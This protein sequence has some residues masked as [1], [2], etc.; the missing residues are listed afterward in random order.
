MNLIDKLSINYRDNADI[1]NPF[2]FHISSHQEN[3]PL[4]D[5]MVY[6]RR[7]CVIEL[8]A[9]PDNIKIDMQ[10]IIYRKEISI[11]TKDRLITLKDIFKAEWTLS[12]M[13]G[14]I[15]FKLECEKFT[16]GG[17]YNEEF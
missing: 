12:S 9:N 5:T 3:I 10:D 13:T 8:S 2:Y 1:I 6:G 14:C 17:N 16:V 11:F 7:Y 15:E 4:I